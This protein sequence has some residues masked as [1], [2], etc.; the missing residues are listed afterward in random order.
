MKES[1]VMT[2][3]LT[4]ATQVDKTTRDGRVGHLAYISSI[5]VNNSASPVPSSHRHHSSKTE[6]DYGNGEPMLMKK[7]GQQRGSE[8]SGATA[9]D[10][11][12]ISKTRSGPFFGSSWAE[13][14]QLRA[15][16]RVL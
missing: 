5:C 1:L 12:A 13:F 3:S 16:F 11:D 2:L 15:L 7:E 8:K 4:A 10:A 14:V 6:A 9:E